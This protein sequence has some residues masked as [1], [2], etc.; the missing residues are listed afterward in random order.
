MAL[1]RVVTG[2]YGGRRAGSFASKGAAS[3]AHPVGE[4]TRVVTGLYGGRRAGSFAGKTSGAGVS[5]PVGV[6]TRVVTGL[7]GGRRAGSFLDKTVAPVVPVVTTAPGGMTFTPVRIGQVSIAPGILEVAFGQISARG[8]I[9]EQS[10]IAYV[11]PAQHVVV[12]Y[13]AVKTE[14]G[15]V[16][17]AFSRYAESNKGKGSAEA[18]GEAVA[19]SGCVDVTSGDAVGGAGGWVRMSNTAVSAAYGVTQAA[20]IRNLTDM[21][22][23]MMYRSMR[24]ARIVAQPKKV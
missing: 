19:A 8:G 18:G 17:R 24:R 21:E 5:H 4:I 11:L 10:A 14:A 6:L 15:A 13:G 9:G 16:G 1:T 2:L 7:Y 12:G 20:G 3:G 23:L 22:V